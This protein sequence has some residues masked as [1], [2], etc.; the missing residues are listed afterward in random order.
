MHYSGEGLRHPE[1]C[2]WHLVSGIED[3]QHLAIGI[4]TPASMHCVQMGKDEEECT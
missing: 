2:E 1:S 3:E 4:V